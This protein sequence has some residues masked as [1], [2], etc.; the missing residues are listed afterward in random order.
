MYHKVS[1]RYRIILKPI[2][3]ERTVEVLSVLLRH[4]RTYG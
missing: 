3:G 4:E 1:G 2:H